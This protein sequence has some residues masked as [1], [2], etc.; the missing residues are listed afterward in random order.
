MGLKTTMARML[1][2]FLPRPLWEAI[3]RLRGRNFDITN[4]T[5]L[6]RDSADLLVRQ[7]KSRGETNSAQPW[8]DSFAVRQS[9]LRRIDLGNFFKGYLGGWGIDVR[10]PTS[11]RRLVELC[12]SIPPQQFLKDGQLR[13]LARR[14]FADRLPKSVVQETR[15]GYQGADWYL[16]LRANWD[17]VRDETERIAQLP[18]AAAMVDTN[19]LR[20]LLDAGDEVD[21][22][23]RQSE[24]A[25]RL[26]LLRGI[27]G[28]HFLRR[29]S[30]AN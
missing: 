22:N 23:S 3:Y 13:S 7:A 27:S 9:Y 18:A 12:F 29:A 2:P 28:G 17:S 20:G 1:G 11:D 21:W 6:N 30:G 25:Y 14:A 5:A 10:D 8:G 16:G 26:A 15:S 4:W 19:R 24:S